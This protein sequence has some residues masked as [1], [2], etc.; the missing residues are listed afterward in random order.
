MV[1]GEQ[2]SQ[3]DNTKLAHSW[4]FKIHLMYYRTHLNSQ[5]V[6]NRKLQEEK[7]QRNPL[8][9]KNLLHVQNVAYL[10]R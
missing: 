2:L 10:E 1:V 5:N 4:Y 7:R 3:T 8:R 9:V 6:E